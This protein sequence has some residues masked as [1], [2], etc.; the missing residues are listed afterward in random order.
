MEKEY[1]W[2][3][4]S[5][6]GTSV[7]PRHTPT[8]AALTAVGV[9][10]R[11]DKRSELLLVNPHPDTWDS[12][13]LPYASMTLPFELSDD[14]VTLSAIERALGDLIADHGDAYEK[15]AL[16]ELGKAVGDT[17]LAFAERPIFEN[18]S[19]KYSKSAEVWTA[20]AFRY[21]AAEAESLQPT[22]DCVWIPLTAERIAE[23]ASAAR[24]D[25]KEVAGNVLALLE[26]SE[27]MQKM[28]LR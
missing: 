23:L 20:Y 24:V 15:N 10:T 16:E 13:M 27:S 25:G 21:H 18:F 9:I 5:K 8:R 19:L 12:W 22:I 14:Q 6:E 3:K 1:N 28:G 4:G 2:A 26:D 17:A 7:P 11:A